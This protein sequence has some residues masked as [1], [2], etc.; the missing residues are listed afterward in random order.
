MRWTGDVWVNDRLDWESVALGHLDSKNSGVAKQ[1]LMRVI[2][3]D[4]DDGDDDGGDDDGEHYDEV[5]HDEVYDEG[6]CIPPKNPLSRSKCSCVLDILLMMMAMMMMV[7]IGVITTVIAM[8]VMA[9][10]IIL[11]WV[12]SVSVACERISLYRTVIAVSSVS[13]SVSVVLQR[14]STV[15][16]R[17]RYLIGISAYLVVSHRYRCRH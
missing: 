17:Y 15:F 11:S 5:G 12:V 9:M 10:M 14:I 7:M 13:V 4:D 3:G 16:L 8:M 2:N 1:L 6:T